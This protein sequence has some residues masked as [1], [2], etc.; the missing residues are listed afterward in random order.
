SRPV[1][2]PGPASC[3][4]TTARKSIALPSPV[5]VVQQVPAG[6][7]QNWS[8]PGSGRSC[9]C[10]VRTSRGIR[11]SRSTRWCRGR[12]ARWHS[13]GPWSAGWAGCGGVAAVRLSAVVR[14]SA[15]AF[16][17]TGEVGE[18][19]V[20]PLRAPGVLLRHFF[21]EFPDFGVVVRVLAVLVVVLGALQGVVLRAHQVV[22]DVV[23]RGV[24]GRHG[25]SAGCVPFSAVFPAASGVP[26]TGAAGTPAAEGA[27]TTDGNPGCSPQRVRELFAFAAVGA[28]DR[29]RSQHRRRTAA[30]N[31]SGAGVALM[32]R[33]RTQFPIGTSGR[34]VRR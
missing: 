33:R 28:L 20:A 31:R 32:P 12:S 9:S 19:F 7:V 4:S 1:R 10:S 11:W 2:R 23:G 18:Q 27:L 17:A 15:Q 25:S 30:W 6:V 26:A 24:L 14:W 34:G 29:G 16:A 8:A 21:E 13:G 22:D 3:P 5:G